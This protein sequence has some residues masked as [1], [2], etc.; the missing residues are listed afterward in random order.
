[1]IVYCAHVHAHDRDLLL[2]KYYIYPA[3][4][5]NVRV[6]KLYLVKPIKPA[7]VDCVV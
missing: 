7:C 5:I 4:I 2:Y 1:M 6:M 3:F